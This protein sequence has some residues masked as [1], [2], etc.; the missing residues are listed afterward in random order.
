MRQSAVEWYV[1]VPGKLTAVPGFQFA[2]LLRDILLKARKKH[3]LPPPSRAPSPS[4]MN[5]G[6]TTSRF[7]P[8]PTASDHPYAS[9]AGGVGAH[10]GVSPNY[11][12]ESALSSG[13]GLP[14][15]DFGLAEQLFNEGGGVW[16]SGG[17][18]LGF[19]SQNLAF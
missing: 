9:P 6:F 1:S 15:L 17:G 2:Q 4:R 10:P 3:V 5:P 14:E 7:T 16:G 11:G 18:G 8:V 13:F 19:V 12:S